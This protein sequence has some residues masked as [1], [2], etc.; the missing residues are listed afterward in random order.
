MLFR[1]STDSVVTFGDKINLSNTTN[2]ESVDAMIDAEGDTVG[3]H[4]VGE[5]QHS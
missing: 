2:A 5:K 4:L 3:G 1:A